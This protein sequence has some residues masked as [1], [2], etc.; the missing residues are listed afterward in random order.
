MDIA[1]KV[2]ALRIDDTYSDTLKLAHTLGRVNLNKDNVEN[3][4]EYD[5]ENNDNIENEG[6]QEKAKKKKKPRRLE[7]KRTTIVED[8]EKLTGEY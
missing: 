3:N 8:G 4:D 2:Y 5:E 6:Q 1:A 7:G